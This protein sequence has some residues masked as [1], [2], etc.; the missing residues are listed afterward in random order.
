MRA[1]HGYVLGIMVAVILFIHSPK[2][3]GI[4]GVPG[5]VPGPGIAMVNSN[6]KLFSSWFWLG[7]W[8]DF[9]MSLD[10]QAMNR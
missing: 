5:M 4:P 1:L 8:T 6:N 2:F 3:I 10:C 9:L 7:N